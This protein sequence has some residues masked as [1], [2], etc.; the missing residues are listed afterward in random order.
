MTFGKFSVNKELSACLHTALMTVPVVCIAWPSS[1]LYN[2]HGEVH[3][4]LPCWW[5]H[6]AILF[7]GCFFVCVHEG[8]F[9]APVHWLLWINQYYCA[10]QASFASD[11]LSFWAPSWSHSFQY[12][13]T[14]ATL[15]NCY[16]PRYNT[17]WRC[18]R[19]CCGLI[20]SL[21][22]ALRVNIRRCQPA[23]IA[24][25]RLDT[26][27]GITAASGTHPQAEDS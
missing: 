18:R 27:T 19:R 23:F 12:V 11:Q 10:K 14:H 6:L 26:T 2:F 21:C 9:S 20:I 5:Y 22:T 8:S 25:R 13:H 17:N 7:P 24:F 3:Q 15:N 1:R 4:W 16:F